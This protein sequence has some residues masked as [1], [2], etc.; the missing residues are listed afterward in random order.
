MILGNAPKRVTVVHCA[1]SGVGGTG[2]FVSELCPQLARH[3]GPTGPVVF[4][5]VEPLYPDYGCRLKAA[6]IAHYEVRKRRGLD[7]VSRWELANVIRN[8]G[9]D[10]VVLHGGGAGWQWPL[11]RLLGVR[12]RMALVEH[13]P[14]SA[15]ST[16]GGIVRHVIGICWADAVIVVSEPLAVC[17]RSRFS[18]FLR[19]KPLHTIP[20]GI[21]TEFFAPGGTTRVPGS[22]L[23]VGTLSPSKDHATLLRAISLLAGKCSAE[24]CL[25]GDG[26]LR[27]ELQELAHQL[28]VESQVRFLGNVPRTDLVRMYRSASIFTFSTKGEGSPLSLLEAMSCGL[29]VVASD[30]PG[31]REILSKSQCGL[32]TAAGD[33]RATAE[34]IKRLLGDA[35]LAHQMGS[36]GRHYVKI[37][38][39]LTAMAAQYRQVL[40]EL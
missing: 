2:S 39:S 26:V 40:S 11:L 29:P 27:N 35:E 33:A 32:L 15:C 20:N 3:P 1:Y 22:L 25:A 16:V 23:M 10:I 12:N 19:R 30:V 28:G 17:L 36:N 38:H 9:A 5:G 18:S 4:Y 34:A 14:E 31:V 37:N 6:G 13:G 7:L 24:L 21:D 8:T